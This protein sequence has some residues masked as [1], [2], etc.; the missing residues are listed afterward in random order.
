MNALA[1]YWQTE[2]EGMEIE[3]AEKPQVPNVITLM[4]NN[5]NGNFSYKETG[6]NEQM[7]SGIANSKIHRSALID[8]ARKN[9]QE[10]HCRLIVE[11]AKNASRPL[12]TIIN[13]SY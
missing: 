9:A 13:E 11:E 4:F 1:Q 7:V 5:E 2:V 3:N 8:K 10:R 6:E 12:F